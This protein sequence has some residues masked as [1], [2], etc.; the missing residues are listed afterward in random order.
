[1]ILR[2]VSLAFLRFAQK[3]L[4]LDTNDEGELGFGWDVEV[5]ALLGL[6]GKTD[7]LPLLSK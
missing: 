6:T 3:D 7:L 2:Y 4:P 1:M 5:T